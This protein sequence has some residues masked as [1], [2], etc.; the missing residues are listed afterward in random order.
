MFRN[1]INS[2]QWASHRTL[3]HMLGGFALV[4]QFSVQNLSKNPVSCALYLFFWSTNLRTMPLEVILHKSLIPWEWQVCC[5]PLLRDFSTHR[6]EGDLEDRVSTVD[7]P[8]S[9]GVW[10]WCNMPYVHVVCTIPSHLFTSFFNL[11]VFVR[12]SRVHAQVA[13]SLKCAQTASVIGSG[14]E[15]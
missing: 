4:R 12:L 8:R 6:M 7:A 2:F 5:L 10:D 3:G 14:L 1:G 11:S 13:R 15:V 9:E